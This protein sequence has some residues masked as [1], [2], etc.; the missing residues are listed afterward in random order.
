MTTLT[1]EGKTLFDLDNLDTPTSSSIFIDCGYDTA[2]RQKLKDMVLTM[3][4]LRE[5]FDKN[6]LTFFDEQSGPYFV[7]FQ[8][9]LQYMRETLHSHLS[10]VVRC[11]YE[12]S[13]YPL[14]TFTHI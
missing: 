10:D 3:R 8:L 9:R 14:K 6:S 7:I 13:W 4:D 5:E 12:H 1:L 2:V 11:T